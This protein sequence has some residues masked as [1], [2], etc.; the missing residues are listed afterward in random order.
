MSREEEGMELQP[1]LS[2]HII[3]DIIIMQGDLIE[4]TIITIMIMY[5]E[6]T[7]PEPEEGEVVLEILGQDIRTTMK[8]DNEIKDTKIKARDER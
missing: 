2:L 6:E 8:R 5:T 7:I 3:G 4:Q 1:R